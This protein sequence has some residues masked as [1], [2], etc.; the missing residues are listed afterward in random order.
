MS[1]VKRQGYHSPLRSQQ[2][3]RSRAAVLAAGAEL[4]AT[5]GYAATTVDQVAERAGVSKP[6]V[7]NAVG[8]KA[9]LFRVVRDVAM[10]GDDAD[11]AVTQRPSV[12]AIAEATDLADAILATAEHVTA[13]CRRYHPI[14]QALTRADA[15]LAE[16]Y[17]EAE[18]ERLVGAGHLVDRLSTHA[19][20][21]VTRSQAIDRLWLLMSPDNYGR[22]VVE[23]RWSDVDYRT[24]LAESIRDQLF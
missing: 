11:V 5:Q 8:N 10:A 9:T 12:S 21:R 3:A 22:L 2:A 17:T 24:W 23:R 19:P 14:H 18:Q 6:T 16:L 1:D 7:F 15:A 20:T 4:F 13:L